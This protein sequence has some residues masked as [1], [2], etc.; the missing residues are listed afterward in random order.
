M[1]ANTTDVE[2]VWMD[3]PLAPASTTMQ[4]GRHALNDL[5][6]VAELRAPPCS[7]FSLCLNLR[8]SNPRRLLLWLPPLVRRYSGGCGMR[9]VGPHLEPSA[10][11]R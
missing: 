6:S 8:L 3:A 4:L 2:E 9:H 7:T 11:S 5:L 10:A 1:A